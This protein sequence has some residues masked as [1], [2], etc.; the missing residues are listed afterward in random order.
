MSLLGLSERAKHSIEL[1]PKAKG[2][3]LGNPEVSTLVSKTH[4][5]GEM[6]LP[7]GTVLKLSY[8]RVAP[9]KHPVLVDINPALLEHGHASLCGRYLPGEEAELV[10][11]LSLFKSLSIEE[12][13]SWQVRIALDAQS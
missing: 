10:L 11:V 3:Y 1:A 9:T 6:S 8:G 5:A 4:K 7:A 12:L 13:P 2:L